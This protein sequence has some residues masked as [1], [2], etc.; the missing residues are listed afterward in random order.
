MH[1]ETKRRH[2]TKCTNHCYSRHG[3]KSVADLSSNPEKM[4]S[5]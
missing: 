2:Q 4:K 1:E 3:G 5:L